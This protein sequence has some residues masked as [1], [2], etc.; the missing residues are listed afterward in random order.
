MEFA[1]RAGTGVHNF[2]GPKRVK[3]G[4]HTVDCFA[5]REGCASRAPSGSGL[6]AHL[7]PLQDKSAAHPGAIDAAVGSG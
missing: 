5:R 1:T 7:Q 4:G 3:D 6:W 2:L